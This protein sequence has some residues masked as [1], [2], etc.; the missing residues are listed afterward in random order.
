[1]SSLEDARINFY[2]A[3]ED[4]DKATD[5]NSFAEKYL[6]TL[7]IHSPPFTQ[8]EARELIK[9]VGKKANEVKTRLMKTNP[10][11]R[12]IIEKRKRESKMRADQARAEHRVRMVEAESRASAARAKVK[13]TRMNTERRLDKFV[14]EHRMKTRTPEEA[15][16][17]V[18]SELIC[19]ICRGPDRG[20][21]MNNM[22][23]CFGCNHKLVPK[24]E[25]KNYNRAYRRAWK[26][27]KK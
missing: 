24:P 22:S 26:K 4:L 5:F 8:K 18:N 15:D 23:F 19:P 13:S 17:I 21:I 3:L 6:K 14:A 9:T 27:N 12:A 20:N 10:K 7:Q 1:M 25:L 16:K 11:F 2:V